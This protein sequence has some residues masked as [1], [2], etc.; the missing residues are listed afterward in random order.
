MMKRVLIVLALVGMA[1]CDVSAQSYGSSQTERLGYGY[2]TFPSKYF[3][4]RVGID[5][6]H[7]ASDDLDHSCGRRT[8]LNIGFAYGKG[9]S[10][11]IPIYIE[12]GLNYV[13]KG[14]G[15]KEK[16]SKG[17][18]KMDY[19][20]DYLELPIVFKYMYTSGSGF[21]VHVFFGGYFS[22]GIAGSIKKYACAFCNPEDKDRSSH[23]A[24]SDR[25]EAFSRFDAG[26]RFGLG[27]SYSIIYLEFTYDLG[28]ANINHG[29]FDA[30]HNRGAIFN[31]GVNF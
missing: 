17:Q 2:K 26:L 18:R 22:C 3:G 8:R 23:S 11:S 15:D 9:L 27:V 19:N 10:K 24:F 21:G 31:I 4:F 28:L 25:D 12:T 14:G 5:Y 1:I 20:L 7:I 29:S 30:A 13:C 6:T 16:E